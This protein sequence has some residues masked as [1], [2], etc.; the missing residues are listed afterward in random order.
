VTEFEGRLVLTADAILGADAAALP[1]STIADL[2]ASLTTLRLAAD[3]LAAWSPESAES[4]QCLEILYHNYYK[5]LRTTEH[6]RTISGLASGHL[7]FN[8]RPLELG[9]FLSDIVSSVRH[10][11]EDTGVTLE[12][13]PPD[14]LI[15]VNAD[16][17]LLEQMVLNLLSNSYQHTG[18]GSHIVLKLSCRQEQVSIL[19]RDDGAGIPPEKQAALLQYGGRRAADSLPEGGSGLGLAL[20]AEAARKHGGAILLTSRPGEGTTVCVRLRAAGKSQGGLSMP[21]P[22][23]NEQIPTRALAELSIILP[24]SAYNRKKIFGE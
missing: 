2:S 19:V 11:T 3:R 9:A 8:P 13:E 15:T 4:E 5:I 18:A 23:Y 12:Y 1:D 10:L 7:L 16:A 14:A 6:L 20:A 17:G 22:L 21:P 24:A